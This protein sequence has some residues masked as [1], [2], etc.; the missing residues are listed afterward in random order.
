MVFAVC[1]G[2]RDQVCP[3]RFVTPQLVTGFHS[4]QSANHCAGLLR[5]PKVS[6]FSGPK[7]LLLTEL[8]L[9]LFTL[10]ASV[11]VPYSIQFYFPV[12]ARIFS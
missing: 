12:N 8:V 4:G 7:I 2:M 10:R 11:P 1:G 5:V 6:N 9:L 3:V